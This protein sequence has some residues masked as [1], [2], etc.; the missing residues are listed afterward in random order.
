MAIDLEDLKSLKFLFALF[1]TNRLSHSINLFSQCL[2]YIFEGNVINTFLTKFSKEAEE[3]LSF[4][5]DNTQITE[6]QIIQNIIKTSNIKLLIFFTSPKYNFSLEKLY[7]ELLF[8]AIKFSTS[9]SFIKYIYYDLKCSIQVSPSSTVVL[10]VNSR[11]DNSDLFEIIKFVNESIIKLRPLDFQ[12][13]S[14]LILRCL[15]NADLL[16]ICKYLLGEDG[17][18]LGH[19]INLLSSFSLII[20]TLLN[21]SKL[22]IVE[23]ILSIYPT[24]YRDSKLKNGFPDLFLYNYWENT[25]DD[26][27][28]RYLF[29]K[30]QGKIPNIDHVAMIKANNIQLYKMT[31]HYRHL[32]SKGNVFSSISIGHLG[33]SLFLINDYIDRTAI[34]GIPS[35]VI[36]F[37][38]ACMRKSIESRVLKLTQTILSMI[39]FQL[40]KETSPQSALSNIQ[41]QSLLENSINS[42]DFQIFKFIV[43]TFN[44][45]NSEINFKKNKMTKS[46]SIYLN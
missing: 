39:N 46:M 42:K 4:L 10:I 45:K 36:S 34:I 16:K 37:L 17:C 32:P 31:T 35:E 41:I 29:S 43:D 9:I 21:H 1:N 3:I 13:E 18:T 2:Q 5:L 40:S 25:K 44:L 6:S 7:P 24:I 23:Y 8:K 11:A 30:N 33:M 12:F 14:L 20:S 22:E 19:K 26:E 15:D 38:L 27:V 28:I